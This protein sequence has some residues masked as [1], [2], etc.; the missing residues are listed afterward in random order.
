MTTASKRLKPGPVIAVAVL[1]VLLVGIWLALR[2]TPVD[3]SAGSAA[4]SANGDA[5]TAATKTRPI[6][7]KQPTDV[8]RSLRGTRPD[9]GVR[10]DAN[11]AP[12]TDAELRR[13]FD[14]YL[15][16]LGEEG[17][18]SIRARLQRDLQQR[19]S[20]LQVTSVLGWFDRYVDYQQA[21]TELAGEP[22]LR[23]RLDAVHELRA[24]MLGDDAA[25]GFFGEEE[26]EAQRV[27]TL[28]EAAGDPSLTPAQ[29]ATMQQRVD[30]AS[31]DYAQ[32]RNENALRV[33]MAQ[34]DA[35]FDQ[36][37]ASAAERRAQR[38]ALVGPVA[39]ER[40]AQLDEQRA[41]WTARTAAYAQQR[42]QLEARTD[43]AAAQRAA[44]ERQLLDGFSVEEQRRVQALWDS[45]QLR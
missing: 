33:Q 44:A 13:Y 45:G 31:P 5:G 10:F 36:A 4:R 8:P 29:R 42:T 24:R 21:G 6:A 11:G 20:P 34:L 14:W 30:A 28:Q 27:L 38:S 7:A 32:A 2:V 37:G 3:T 15:A 35:Q 18:E 19:M 41:H 16:T 40:F 17:V 23:M 1:L 22:D 12:V 39:A 26:T 9:G 25:S 43:L